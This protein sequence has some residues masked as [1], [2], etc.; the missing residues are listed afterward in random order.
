MSERHAARWAGA[1]FLG[2]F[3]AASATQLRAF[4]WDTTALHRSM[5][6]FQAHRKFLMGG[7]FA[8]MA[9]AF[10]LAVLALELPRLAGDGLRARTGGAMLGAAAIASAVAGVGQ[11][12]MGVP[13]EEY[14][15]AGAVDHAIET[16]ADS[17]YWLQDNL[18]TLSLVGLGVAAV[19][20][21]PRLGRPLLVWTSRLAI[22]GA[23]LTA[24]ALMLNAPDSRN[25]PL[26]VPAFSVAVVTTFVWVAAASVVSVRGPA[27][28]P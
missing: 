20:L 28:A 11:V 16:L 13:A 24:G 12:V 26:Y 8:R 1:A 19:A 9:L 5:L 14:V 22:A 7:G 17:F 10:P 18:V 15:R 2:L 4:W 3:A 25:S 27:P 23:L 6:D 21:T